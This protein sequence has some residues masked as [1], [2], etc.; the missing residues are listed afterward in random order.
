MSQFAKLSRPVMSATASLNAY[1]ASRK[2][3]KE[4]KNFF[5]K[6]LSVENFPVVPIF[7]MNLKFILGNIQSY[8]TYYAS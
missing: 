3:C 4:R 7:A 6:K 5:P 8:S 1:Q 2:V